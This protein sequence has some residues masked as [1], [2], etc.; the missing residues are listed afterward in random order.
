MERK[1]RPNVKRCM[2]LVLWRNDLEE[3]V[4]ILGARG[5]TVEIASSDYSFESVAELVEHCGVIHPLTNL[6]I[7][8]SKPYTTISLRR[9]E[10]RLYVAEET[11]SGVFFELSKIL[12][13]RQRR[14]PFLYSFP[15][16]YT[17]IVLSIWPNAIGWLLPNFKEAASGW[18]IVASNV[19]VMVGWVCWVTFIRLRH[20]VVIRLQRH[21]DRTSFFYRKKDELALLITGA[22][23][24]GVITFVGTKLVDKIFK[25]ETG[26]VVAPTPHN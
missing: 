24:G 1:P 26:H 22:I 7:V 20:Y 15:F 11:G 5:G 16:V 8:G 21:S 2:P 9:F 17:I 25:A 10:A 23:V 19:A 3:I 4:D 18:V 12:A 6:E 13:P 14:W